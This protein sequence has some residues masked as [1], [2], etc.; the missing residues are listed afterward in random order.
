MQDSTDSTEYATV[1]RE[2]FE[3]SIIPWAGRKYEG[4]VR[5]WAR[6]HPRD[7]TGQVQVPESI[8]RAFQQRT[9]GQRLSKQQAAALGFPSVPGEQEL[10]RVRK[11]LHEALARSD[12]ERAHDLDAEMRALL[13]T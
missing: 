7:P 13:G 10:A 11:E 9:F 3:F 1:A 4:W 2:T 6:K 8:Y 5:A 12:W